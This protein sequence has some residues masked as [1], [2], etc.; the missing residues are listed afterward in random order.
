MNNVYDNKEFFDAYAQMSRS[1]DGLKSTG[2]WHQLQPL[3]PPLQGKKV[4]DLGCGY[5]WHSK[6]AADQ[7]AASVLGLD[8]SERMIEEARRR[9]SAPNGCVRTILKNEGGEED[10]YCKHFQ[11]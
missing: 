11:K 10:G 2:E 5:G 7:G 3:F 6:F 8:L 4:L 1:K 9:N